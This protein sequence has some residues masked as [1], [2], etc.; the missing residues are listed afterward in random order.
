MTWIF[1][2]QVSRIGVRWNWLR[3]VSIGWGL[4]YYQC[5]SLWILP[6]EG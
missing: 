3:I 5:S 2:R 1:K 6:S 4:W